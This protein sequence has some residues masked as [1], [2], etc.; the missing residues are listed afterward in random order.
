MSDVTFDIGN[1]SMKDHHL[2]AEPWKV[3]LV[4]TGADT[5]AGGRHK[6]VASNLDE[7]EPF[8]FHIW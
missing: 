5:Q 6:R 3:T 8:L 1:N 7:H 4:D 2:K